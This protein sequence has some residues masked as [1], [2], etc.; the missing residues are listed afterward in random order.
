MK[1]Y[2]KW[3]TILN[4][5]FKKRLKSTYRELFLS[6]SINQTVFWY[7][8]LVFLL[9]LSFVGQI[10]W[11]LSS[12]VPGYSDRYSKQILLFSLVQLLM[13]TAFQSFL[14]KLWSEQSPNKN[15]PVDLHQVRMEAILWYG[16]NSISNFVLRKSCTKWDRWDGAPS[17]ENIQTSRLITFSIAGNNSLR[18]CQQ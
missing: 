10:V 5:L 18:K 11:L 6:K 16:W 1:L 3:C 12:S 9:Q 7:A 14:R 17:W 15:K 13:Q 2:F 8:F 4:E